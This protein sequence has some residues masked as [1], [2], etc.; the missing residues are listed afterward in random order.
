MI[1][2]LATF[3]AIHVIISLA[4]IG[5][6]LVVV[7]GLIAGRRLDGWTAVFLA[8]TVLTSVTG[9]GFSFDHLLPSHIV[10]LISL[11]VLAAAIFARY[12]RG[13]AGGWRRVYV[14]GAVVA[15]WFNVFVLIVQS[16]QK[17]PA[18][19]T[20]APTQSEPPFLIAQC[21]ALVLFIAL[22]AAATIKFRD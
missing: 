7:F 20:L 6:G 4:G 14:I 19:K 22:G 15:L 18:L 12:G 9:F 10:G 5:S 17:V 1:V 11:V 3:T 8:T 2:S 13:L 16:F 21:A